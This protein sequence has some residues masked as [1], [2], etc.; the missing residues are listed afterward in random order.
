MLAGDATS[1]GRGWFVIPLVGE[2]AA[3]GHVNEVKVEIE[4]AWRCCELQTALVGDDAGSR[5]RWLVMALV[6]DGTGC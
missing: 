4:A 5:R 6:R 3:H 1:C 2:G